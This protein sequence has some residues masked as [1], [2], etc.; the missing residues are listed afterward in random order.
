M[1]TCFFVPIRT[2]TYVIIGPHTH[3][4]T[5][6]HMAHSPVNADRTQVEDTG[7]AHHHIQRDKD[8]TV[9]PAEK[10][11][12]ADHLHR[13]HGQ[14]NNA[15]V[16]LPR[17]N[18]DVWSTSPGAHMNA[19]VWQESRE[20]GKMCTWD[21]VWLI[22]HSKYICCHVSLHIPN[23]AFMLIGVLMRLIYA[24]FSPYV[25]VVKHELWW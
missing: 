4:H 13:T 22:L 1:R 14:I 16:S 7:G 24:W 21:L 6:T 20:A 2:T 25:E 15:H 3:T 23:S 9:E 10:P 19:L 18:R 5:H 8:V 11:G 12:A 17:L